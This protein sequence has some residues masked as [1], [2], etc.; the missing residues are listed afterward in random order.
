VQS[1][2]F[3]GDEVQ[4][5]LDDGSERRV[6]HVL[7][8]TGYDVDIA[9]YNFLSPELLAGVRRLNGYPDLGRGFSTSIPGL[10]FIGA[11]AARSFGPLLYFVA[12]T[13]FASKELASYISQHNT[14]N[15]RP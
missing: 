11:A 14:S 6:D 13:E 7:L 15:V 2:R 5:I 10:H 8:G 3:Q 12:G 4:L 9:R 1:A